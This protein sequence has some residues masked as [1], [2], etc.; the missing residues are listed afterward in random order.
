MTKILYKENN[1]ILE[2]KNFLIF[3]KIFFPLKFFAKF[4]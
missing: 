2:L 1:Q 4:S 3:S